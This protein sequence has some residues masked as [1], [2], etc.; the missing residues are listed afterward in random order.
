M[1]GLC[2]A[3]DVT[4]DLRRLD[5]RVEKRKRCRRIISKLAFEPIPIDGPAVEPGRRPRLEPAHLQAEAIKSFRKPNRWR[6]DGGAADSLVVRRGAA[7][8]NF[9]FANVNEPMQESACRQHHRACRDARA[10]SRN[11][12]RGTAIVH[13]EVFGRRGPD[14]QIGDLIQS[15]L[16][17]PL[18][19]LAVGLGPWAAYSGAFASVEDTKLD[20]AGIGD[21]SHQSI[22]RI[23][24]S[25]EM[26]LTHPADGRITGHLADGFARVREQQCLGAKARRR[27]CGLTACVPTPDDDDVIRHAASFRRQARPSQDGDVSRETF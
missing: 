12:A 3:C 13:N 17:R 6:F 2:G 5:A 20:P 4:G 9:Y 26:A 25:H 14:F 27:R 23:D 19:K 11:D 18:V 1:G 7:S 24:F 22:K 21:P 10:L 8:W 16:H 15:S